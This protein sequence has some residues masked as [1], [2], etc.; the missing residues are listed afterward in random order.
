MLQELILH[1][2][3][4]LHPVLIPSSFAMPSSLRILSLAKA[5][6]ASARLSA[7]AAADTP[8]AMQGTAEDR[9]QDGFFGLFS[10]ESSREGAPQQDPRFLPASLQTIRLEK[11]PVAPG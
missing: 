4:F 6:G 8:G 10:P 7:R 2:V 9:R 5:A 1:R 3:V 11:L